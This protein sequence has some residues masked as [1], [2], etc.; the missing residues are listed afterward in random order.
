MVVQAFTLTASLI[1]LADTVMC[2]QNEMWQESRY[3]SEAKMGELYG[4]GRT[5]GI[6][7]K[8]NWTRL[9]AEARKMIESGLELSDRIEAAKDIN[10][11][12]GSR[13]PG[14]LA[15]DRALH[16]PSRH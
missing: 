10:R 5:L 11:V 4:E 14:R 16:Q 12:P 13:T 6:D 7:G 8:V 15:S 9:E 1:R 3:F 2:E